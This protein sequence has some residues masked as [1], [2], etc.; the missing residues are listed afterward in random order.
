MPHNL[1]DQITK[2][3]SL[4]DSLLFEIDLIPLSLRTNNLFHQ[5]LDKLEVKDYKAVVDIT[6]KRV[7]SMVS[8]DYSLVT[9][10]LA[11]KWAKEIFKDVFGLKVDDQLMPF[12]VISSQRKTFC[13]IDLIHKEYEP[14]KIYQDSWLPYIRI[15]NSYNKTYP[16][17]FQIGFLRASCSN[18]LVISKTFTFKQSHSEIIYKTGKSIKEY[19]PNY[20][21]EINNFNL[22]KNEFINYMNGLYKL[23]IPKDKINPLVKKVLSLKFQTNHPN[24]Q[25][26]QK[27]EQK[28]AAYNSKVG[29]LTEK[30]S[31]E[32]ENTAYCALNVM[33]DLITY[34][35]DYECIPGFT[36]KSQALNLRVYEWSQNFP[37]E[38]SKKDF[39]WEI[40]LNN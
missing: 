8:N 3:Q 24:T 36:T 10:K 31:K 32:L 26:R 25:F 9:N 30:Y 15:T 29:D 19:I 4:L 13:H 16:L 2:T 23:H 33:T 5:E 34:G 40:Y 37:V 21:N 18:G 39:K 11:I 20:N 27:A 6:M 17:I 7:L 28:E 1:K 12:K 22:A 38:F 35:D 14:F